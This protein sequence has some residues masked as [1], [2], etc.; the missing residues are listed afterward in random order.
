MAVYMMFWDGVGYGR[1]DESSN[2]FFA[3]TLPTFLKVF[4]GTMPSL[5]RRSLS[6]AI[7]TTVPVNT[8]LGIRGL[9]QS[10][11]GQAAIFTGVNAPKIV[12]KHFGP[13]PY[14]SLIPIIQ[15]KNLF[16]Q[17]E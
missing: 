8:T 17:L 5:K 4:G 10:G 14:T 6:S 11:T 3:A 7:A 13:H 9:P 15:E 2:P 16:V 1:E 12:G